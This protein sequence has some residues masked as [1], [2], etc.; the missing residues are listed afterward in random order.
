L[1]LYYRC[2]DFLT[3]I[4][5]SQFTAQIEAD[6]NSLRGPT[7]GRDF[8]RSRKIPAKFRETAG[9]LALAPKPDF[10]DGVI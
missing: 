7:T 9:R 3:L 4:F 8:V 2:L 10:A 1:C 6:T 5:S